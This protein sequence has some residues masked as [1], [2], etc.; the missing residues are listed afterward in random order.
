MYICAIGC[1]CRNINNEQQC[2]NLIYKVFI[3]FQTNSTYVI[4]NLLPIILGNLNYPNKLRRLQTNLK[5]S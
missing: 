1:L 2:T 3:I 5:S 4:L